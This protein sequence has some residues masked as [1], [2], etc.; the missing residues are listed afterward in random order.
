MGAGADAMSIEPGTSD[1]I[2][3]DRAH[4]ADYD[5]AGKS[6]QQIEHD[7]ADTRAELGELLDEIE[8]KLAPRQLLER[9][10]DM[11]KDTMSGDATG[12]GET[13]R[14]NPVPLALIGIGVGWM[15]LSEGT[16]GKVSERAGGLARQLRDKV[17]G[18]MPTSD[19]AD[20]VAYA[21]EEP[22]AGYAYA[23]PKSSGV[24]GEAQERLSRVGDAARQR[25][26]RAGEYAGAA[27]ERLNDV[28]SR[29]GELVEDHPLAVGMLGILAGAVVAL[30][31]PRSEVEDRFVGPA[32]E[33]VRRRAAELGREA[34]D[35]A[36]E[37]V[38]RTADAAADA[39][40]DAAHRT[41]G[42]GAGQ[43]AG[44]ETTTGAGDRI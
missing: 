34:A 20:P 16:R 25:M 8:R 37:V 13:L 17:R 35:R 22:S 23:R 1:V 9:G 28:R 29:V 43:Y 39:V 21:S 6:P 36:Q 27:G 32:G 2:L 42:G 38:E 14:Q 11:L 15:L 3:P 31:L 24:M 44:P 4:D 40:R 41:A 19:P 30:L 7:I 10:M 18:S 33:E 12:L 5:A 26:E